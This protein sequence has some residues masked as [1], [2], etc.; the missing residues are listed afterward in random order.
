MS[1]L[2]HSAAFILNKTLTHSLRYLSDPLILEC[3]PW[4]TLCL[5]KIKFPLNQ[6]TGDCRILSHYVLLFVND[7]SITSLFIQAPS[8]QLADTI[9]GYFVPGVLIVSV[10]TLVSWI[11]VGYVNINLV[12]PMYEV[13][14]HVVTVVVHNCLFRY[15]VERTLK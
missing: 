1:S 2:L 14:H 15:F 12:D 7:V 6:F 3:T 5:M 11:I 8:Q 13:S 10:L 4:L 9:A